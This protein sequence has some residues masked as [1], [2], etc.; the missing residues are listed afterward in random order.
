ME[1]WTV[2][3]ENQKLLGEFLPQ[4]AGFRILTPNLP[5]AWEY[6]Y[7]NSDL[8]LKMDQYGPVYAQHSPPGGIQL[9]RRENGQRFSP[10]NIWLKAE[11]I[12]Q[13]QPFSAFFRPALGNDPT[14]LPQNYEVIFRPESALYRIQL[15]D[16]T[17]ETEFL[18]PPSG[19]EIVMKCRVQNTGSIAVNLCLFPCLVP[20]INPA[21]LAPWDKYEWYLKSAVVLEKQALFWSQLL[22]SESDAQKR[23]TAILWT[24]KEALTGV[25][26][27]LE[28]FIGASSLDFPES[29]FQGRLRL[30]P[31]SASYGN[32]PPD[33]TIYGYPPIYAQQYSWLLT[34]GQEQV[35]TQVLALP[36]K[37]QSSWLAPFEEVKKSLF[38]FS[39]HNFSETK[40]T[41][42]R[43]YQQIF[44]QNQLTTGQ[45]FFDYYV[46]YWLP[47]QMKWVCALD[48]G[49]PTGMRGTRDSAQ[50]FLALLFT[51]DYP[52]CRQVL[53]QLLSCQRR[54]GWF[55]RQYSA[56][57]RQGKHDL[58]SYIDGGAFV[59]EFAWNYLAHSGDFLLLEETLPWLDQDQEDQVI[60]H[61]LTAL[62]YYLLPE[63]IGEHGLCKLREGDW[64]D[65]LNRAGTKGRGESVMVSAQVIMS[66]YYMTDLLKKISLCS[67]PDQT[68][69]HSYP[70]LEDRL[71]AFSTASA[72]LKKA[73]LSAS[74]NPAGFF[75]G[76]FTDKGDWIF[77]GQD[78]DG[79]CRPY[80]P[81]NWY[82]IIAG[83]LP[84]V[85]GKELLHT[86]LPM[87]KGPFGYRL[88]HPP[89]GETPIP[90]TGR[91]GSGDT[92][93]YQGENGNVYNHGSQ[94]FL[95]RALGVL[96]E[97]DELFEVL[98]WLFP[99]DQEKHPTHQALSAPYAITNCW[100]ESSPF[101]G[102]SL[103]TFLTGSVAMGM[104]GV[105]EWMLGIIP[106]LDGLLFSPVLPSL[107]P[108]VQVNSS[109][110]GRRI[111]LQIWNHAGK[112]TAQS[113]LVFHGVE[114]PPSLHP[115]YPERL[116]FALR[117]ED[118]KDNSVFEIFL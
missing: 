8:L 117:E 17:V 79:H 21:M 40:S 75:N 49:W 43:M 3:D 20:Y 72:A 105:Y 2:F 103:M 113:R 56:E 53:L 68:T 91:S 115:F 67:T 16:L 111:Q 97:G 109:F 71:A 13:G 14:A 69:L 61:L 39:A 12:N 73:L 94:G 100:Q 42:Q 83:L 27:S 10:W 19:C 74:L 30:K 89:M 92:P 95:A 1:S 36:A 114:Y 5:S 76:A 84:Q 47:L 90:C 22:N 34:P 48:R 106:E 32:Y 60:T 24:D 29:I 44:T 55:P 107:I 104:R 38:Y 11:Q 110:R 4:T 86:L 6:I 31:C 96:Q 77:S 85:Q 93:P 80:G 81:T 54:D 99:F 87:L 35:L 57:G 28:K 62:D 70:D 118:I 102:R 108:Q 46:N 18:I 51:G 116:V 112:V 7:Q 9:F 25:E 41:M 88:Y 66:L 37:K 78:P 98:N 64:L 63:N 26:I 59:I 45:E 82:A 50:D 15:D 58:R 65:S 101:P 33:H 52:T 23:Q